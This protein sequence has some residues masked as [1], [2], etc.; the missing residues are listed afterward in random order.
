[1]VDGIMLFFENRI[2][3]STINLGFK[4]NCDPII[5]GKSQYNNNNKLLVKRGPKTE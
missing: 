5:N 4:W 3:F 2:Q 1:M